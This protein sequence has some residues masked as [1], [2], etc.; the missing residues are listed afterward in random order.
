MCSQNTHKD[1]KISTLKDKCI[2][3]EIIASLTKWKYFFEAKKDEFDFKKSNLKRLIEDLE[4][5]KNFLKENLSR[6]YDNFID[7]F[8]KNKEFLANKI[9]E[10]YI[11]EKSIITQTKINIEKQALKL[12]SYIA[13]MECLAHDLNKL[14]NQEILEIDLSKISELNNESSL[15]ILE[16]IK[17]KNQNFKFKDFNSHE[18]CFIKKNE[19]MLKEYLDTNRKVSDDL[20]RANLSFKYKIN[21]KLSDEFNDLDNQIKQKLS[22]NTNDV[23]N[24]QSPETLQSEYFKFNDNNNDTYNKVTQQKFGNLKDNKLNLDNLGKISLEAFDNINLLNKMNVN[25]NEI[26]MEE[27]LSE[28][29]NNINNHSNINNIRHNLALE[30]N[31]NE[32]INLKFSKLSLSSDNFIESPDNQI[33]K[34]INNKNN[35]SDLITFGLAASNN[36]H[37]NNLR[38]EENNAA[39]TNNTNNLSNIN[40]YENNISQNNCDRNGTMRKSSFNNNEIINITNINFIPYYD[41]SSNNF[42]KM[43]ELENSISSAKFAKSSEKNYISKL[44]NNKENM[45]YKIIKNEEDQLKVNE[46]YLNKTGFYD[47]DSLNDL[48]LFIGDSKDK[49]I[50]LF[51]TK[52]FY[53]IKLENSLLGDYEFLDYSCLSQFGENSYIVTG[54]CIY[55][56]YKN[57]AVN[58]TYILKIL[59]YKENFLLSCVPFKQMNKQ[60]FSHCSCNLRKKVYVYGGHDGSTTLNCIEYFNPEENKWKFV[61]ET[62][63]KTLP[64]EMNIE[65]EIFASCT[66]D[67]KLIYVFGG[68]NDIHVDTIER[69]DVD[70]GKWTI[71]PVKLNVP[72]QNCTSC[73]LGNNEIAILGGFNGT[74]HRNIDVL[75]IE[76]QNWVN[77]SDEPKLIIPRRR[78]HC[79]KYGDKVNSIIAYVYSC[80]VNF[81]FFLKYNTAVDNWRR[82]K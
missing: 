53:W 17:N 52:N 67:D 50:L 69:F 19:I 61:Y 41:R 65:R 73:Y 30:G 71:L 42:H 64:S 31:L 54:G 60:R 1:H 74:V 77:Y 62:E 21:K 38:I 12:R 78:A 68:F 48:I 33:N 8:E 45:N 58:S 80:F 10:V 39:L 6:E 34:E 51:N 81:F 32:N 56:N 66:V 55:S 37:N 24:F 14:S 16:S 72:L 49:S 75:N 27:S 44:N 79:Y 40:N 15:I 18:D 13:E 3:D 43:C 25:S 7:I 5:N 59:H 35:N 29:E 70:S 82:G 47:F 63:D 76:K 57:T 20:K 4:N 23:V 36:N 11:K 2:S 22:N 9:K 46:N 26:F 28:N